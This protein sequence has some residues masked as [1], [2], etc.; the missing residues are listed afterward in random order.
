[1]K[2]IKEGFNDVYVMV[3]KHK[4]FFKINNSM[5]KWAYELKKKTNYW[6]YIETNIDKSASKFVFVRKIG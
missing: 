6:F 5:Y 2:N 4:L 1:M 3:E